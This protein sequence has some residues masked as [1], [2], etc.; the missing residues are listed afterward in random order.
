MGGVCLRGVST[1]GR[2]SARGVSI[3]GRCLPKGGV[4]PRRMSQT[5]NN[6]VSRGEREHNFLTF[7]TSATLLREV[8]W[9]SNGLSGFAADSELVLSGSTEI[10]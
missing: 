7:R 3:Q 8:A 9:R 10:A 1:Q 5:G 4:Y 6:Y 2:V